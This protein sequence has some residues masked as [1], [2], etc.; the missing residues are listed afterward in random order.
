MEMLSTVVVAAYLAGGR[1]GC[2]LTLKGL[3]QPKEVMSVATETAKN[4]IREILDRFRR[5]GP[6]A[7]IKLMLRQRQWGVNLRLFEWLC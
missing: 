1:L 2:V 5:A 4:K 3:P 6:A 7:S